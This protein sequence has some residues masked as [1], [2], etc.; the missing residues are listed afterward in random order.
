MVDENQAIYLETLNLS[1]M[2]SRFGRGISD[3]G[4]YEYSRQLGYKGGWYG[5]YVGKADMFFASSKMCNKCK[6][7]NQAL[8]LSDRTWDCICGAHHDRDWN[9]AKNILEYGRA[10]RNLRTGREGAILLSELSK[11]EAS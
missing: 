8:I 3:S 4:W 1:G 6:R 9:A 11:Q 7:I 5:C 2:M 10:D